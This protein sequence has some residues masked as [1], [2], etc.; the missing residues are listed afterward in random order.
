MKPERSEVGTLWSDVASVQS[1]RRAVRPATRSPSNACG[2]VTSC[3]RWRSMYSRQVPSGDSSTT[4]SAQILSNSVRGLAAAAA[5]MTAE[6]PAAADRRIAAARARFT[7]PQRA[8]LGAE[9]SGRAETRGRSAL[10]AALREARGTQ[11]A[12]QRTPSA[13]LLMA[14]VIVRQCT[15]GGS[16]RAQKML[17]KK[18]IQR[19]RTDKESAR[20]V[21]GSTSGS[22]S[23]VF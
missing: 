12:V 6:A 20:H 4:W 1:G 14:H 9:Q 21:H 2:L 8:S 18:H 10:Q 16:E 13:L 23:V 22:L 3:T 17:I 7:L 19:A 5:A 11:G 15:D